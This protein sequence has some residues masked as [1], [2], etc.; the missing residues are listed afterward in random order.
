MKRRNDDVNVCGLYDEFEVVDA[1]LAG[2]AQPKLA[3]LE[4]HAAGCS[5]C[6][7]YLRQW[8]GLLAD[9]ERAAAEAT[10]PVPRLRLRMKRSLR[11]RGPV[12]RMLTALIS[13]LNKLNRRGLLVCGATAA[14]AACLYTAALWHA[15]DRLRAPASGADFAQA[16]EELISQMAMTSLASTV[17]YPVVMRAPVGGHGVAW[18]NDQSEELLLVVEGLPVSPFDDYRVWSSNAGHRTELGTLQQSAG[19][20]HLHYQGSGMHAAD[21]ITVSRERRGTAASGA[22]EVAAV[23]VK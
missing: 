16:D 11:W 15:A 10:A 19:K 3:E 1:L 4:R 2:Q 9:G 13:R 17:R 21:T 14:V 6:A 8:R 22:A 12:R 7:A 18:I 23:A 20:A 5:I